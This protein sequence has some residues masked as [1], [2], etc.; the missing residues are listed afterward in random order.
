MTYVF[1]YRVKALRELPF[2]SRRQTETIAV[3]GVSE[4]RSG[5]ASGQI[6]KCLSLYVLSNKRKLGP[7][8][9][10]QGQG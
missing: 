8:K 9:Q 7:G 2:L 1:K 3:V 10:R 5:A 6:R 4:I